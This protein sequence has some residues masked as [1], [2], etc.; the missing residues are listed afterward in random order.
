MNIQI[1][2]IFL[3][4]AIAAITAGCTAVRAAKATSWEKANSLNEC[5][6]PKEIRK[7]AGGP[8]KLIDIPGGGRIEIHDFLVSTGKKS[9]SAPAAAGF[10]LVTLGVSEFI[11]GLNNLDCSGNSS[12]NSKCAYGEQRIVVHYAPSG[13]VAC[14]EVKVLRTG[15]VMTA[16]SRETSSCPMPY[17]TTL[18]REVD[19]SDLPKTS[20]AGDPDKDAQI[21][22]LA[23][24]VQADLLATVR[25]A[26]CANYSN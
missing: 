7:V 6:S 24:S 4:G 10:A 2:S 26:R 21:A 9:Q 19:V 13:G 22:T 11:A 14:L 20:R 25:E 1:G 18:A 23:A 5:S 12:I 17:K 8:D 16:K 3:L 15:E